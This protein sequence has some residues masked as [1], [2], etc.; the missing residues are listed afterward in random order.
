MALRFS[1]FL[2][3]IALAA[4][5]TNIAAAQDAERETIVVTASRIPQ[6]ANSVGSSISVITADEIGKFQERFVLDALTTSPGIDAAR[7]GPPGGTAS[8][9]LRGA[10]SYQTMVLIDGV[11]VNDPSGP[12]S[13]FDF[14]R[15]LSTDIERIEMLRG[16]QSTLYGGDAIGGVINIIT[17]R[18][19][20]GFDASGLV[21][22]GSF[23]TKTLAAR[24]AGGTEDINGYLN[25]SREETTGF[26]GGRKS[27]SAI[28]S[29][30]GWNPPK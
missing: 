18:T 5:A 8:V 28:I 22:F 23:G 24:V 29:M 2:S 26:P 17:K 11:Q 7:A 14:G 15:L 16:P 25:V 9:F 12:Q 27:G 3:G 19:V 13:A 6:D 10:D 1:K 4:L 20:D 30:T 21:E